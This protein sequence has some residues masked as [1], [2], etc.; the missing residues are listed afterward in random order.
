M[1]ARKNE[2]EIHLPEFKPQN[3]DFNIK[4]DMWLCG[5]SETDLNGEKFPGAFPA[6]FLKR[7]KQTFKKYYPT[8]SKEILHVCSGRIPK[9]EGLRLDISNQYNPDFLCDCQTFILANGNR[10][11][12]N[13]VTWCISDTPYNK[14]AANKYYSSTMI[15]RSRVLRQMNRVTKVGGFIGIL[16]QIIPSAPPKNLVMVAKI[17]VS[18]VPNL[19]LRTFSVLKKI[20]PTTDELRAEGSQRLE[21]F[22]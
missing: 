16:D 22:F 20:G 17:G 14:P 1:M 15:E 3:L 10:V 18:S 6:G 19:D 4:T 7:L 11:P 21:E 5:P 2:G 12:E 8:D 13:I 9:E